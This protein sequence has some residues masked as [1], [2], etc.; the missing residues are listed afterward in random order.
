MTANEF[1][2]KYRKIDEYGYNLTRPRV[3]CADGY[4]VSMQAGKGLYSS[5]R[6]DAD[7]YEYVELGFPNKVDELI[8]PYAENPKRP[9]KTVYCVDIEIA[10][11]L[12][13]EHG[14]IVG[15]DFDNIHDERMNVWKGVD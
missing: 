6:H 10:D 1:L 8:V 14:G 11:Y 7:Y 15:A 9:T 13:A 2:Q 5:P 12:F 4:T 3:K